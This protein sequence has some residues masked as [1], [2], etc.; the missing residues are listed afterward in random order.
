M[1][2][3]ACVTVILVVL[4]HLSRRYVSILE[5][6]LFAR[7]MHCGRE[8]CKQAHGLGEEGAYGLGFTFIIL[9]VS[10]MLKTVEAQ[11]TIV[12]HD[13]LQWIYMG[14]M[15]FALICLISD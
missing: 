14:L 15:C 12:D 10:Q 11:R 13:D 5:L 3:D 6:G 2:C 9:F 7:C 1:P 8:S 4:L